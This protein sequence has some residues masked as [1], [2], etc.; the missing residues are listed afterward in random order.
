MPKRT[1]LSSGGGKTKALKDKGACNPEIGVTGITTE[2]S[3]IAISIQGTG[4]HQVKL[5]K[6]SITIIAPGISEKSMQVMAHCFNWPAG[7]LK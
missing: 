6:N 7:P 4:K 1:D 3:H 5:G 2:H